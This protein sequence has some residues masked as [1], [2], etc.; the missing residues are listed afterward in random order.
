MNDVSKTITNYNSRNSTYV[1]GNYILDNEILPYY[2]R[3]S[4]AIHDFNFIKPSLIFKIKDVNL[5]II[6]FA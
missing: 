1:L 6:L 2:I 3:Y 5:I 4:V